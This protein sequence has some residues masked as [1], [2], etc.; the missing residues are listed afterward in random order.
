M[1]SRKESVLVL[2]S[3]R[4]TLTVLRSLER[5]GYRTILG[6]DDSH[7]FSR[8]SRSCHEVWEHPGMLSADPTFLEALIGFVARRR[9]VRWIFPV[10][11][12]QLR[13]FV[14][15]GPRVG[16]A[17]AVMPDPHVV[18]M[19]LDKPSLYLRAMHCGVACAPYR[20]AT[21]AQSLDG[22]L[23]ALGYPVVV[24]PTSSMTRI[25]DRSALVLR[26]AA[27]RAGRLPT[28]FPAGGPLLVQKYLDGKRYHCQFLANDGA[29]LAYLEQEVLRTDLPDGTG[30][31]VDEITVGP[32]PE[33]RGQCEALLA[34]LRY[35]G[36]GCVEFIVGREGE[37]TLLE[38]NPRLDANCALAYHAGYDFPALA[39]EFARYRRGERSAPPLC[40]WAY[41][42]G[43]RAIWTTGE[44]AGIRAG[45]ARP[46][47]QALASIGRTLWHA[48]RADCHPVW[49]W[50]DPSPALHGLS[51]LCRSSLGRL[52]E[53]PARAE[54]HEPP[55]GYGK[56]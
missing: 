4:Q 49:S 12:Q 56:I 33:L 8:Y 30:H 16:I 29:L 7:T 26:N 6:T 45:T 25:A 22:A 24:R 46:L 11:E 47:G 21:D 50:S 36:A 40:A 41:P 37:M 5:A 34:H 43:R 19:C 18:S 14:G 23:D 31:S 52:L 39:L 15:C 10:G 35:S 28:G 20:I 17:H 2:G 53:L 13:F 48:A 55:S 44:L 51:R 3:L 27:E 38:I 54:R 1:I 42:T 9:D 32:H